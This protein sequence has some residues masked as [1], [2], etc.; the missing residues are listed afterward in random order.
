IDEAHHLLSDASSPIGVALPLESA[1]LITVH[2]EHLPTAIL[3][4]IATVIGIGQ[5]VDT[6][7]RVLPRWGGEAATD[8]DVPSQ[9]HAWVWSNHLGAT[10]IV[11]RVIPPEAHRRRHRRKYS[12]GELGDDK[13]FFF[14]GPDGKLNLRAQNLILFIQL[15]EGVDA[16]TWRFHLRKGD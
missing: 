9:D 16:E 3:E 4:S 5:T 11:F 6:V 7:L 13:S 1:L 14:R 12:E 10:P 2:P 8:V 15:A